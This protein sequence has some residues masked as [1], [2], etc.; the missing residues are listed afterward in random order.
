MKKLMI[1]SIVSLTVGLFAGCGPKN[2]EGTYVAN[3]KSEYSVAEDTIVLKGNIIT[4]RVGYRRILNGE[5]KPKEFSL[6]KWILNAPDAPIIEF[7]EHQITIGKTVYK[8]I[9]Q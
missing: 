2:H 5:F 4:N 1:G 8:Q 9:D 6:K 7:G 3:V